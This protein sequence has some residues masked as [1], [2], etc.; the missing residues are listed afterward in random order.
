MDT[1]KSKKSDP[2]PTSVRIKR[3]V[4]EALVEISKS[5]NRSINV[6]LNMAAEEFIKNNK[7]KV[8]RVIIE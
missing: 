8:P 1:Q 2:H 5:D 3:H 4:Y 6:L 7:Y